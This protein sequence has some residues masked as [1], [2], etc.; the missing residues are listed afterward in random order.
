MYFHRPLRVFCGN[1]LSSS[2]FHL[3]LWKK[4]WY[5]KNRESEL[6][7]QAYIFFCFSLMGCKDPQHPLP[8]PPWLQNLWDSV[9]ISSVSLGKSFN[10]FGLSGLL[11]AK[12]VCVSRSILIESSVLEKK[13][14]VLNLNFIFTEN[15][16]WHFRVYRNVFSQNVS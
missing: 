14:K 7:G 11:S 9:L 8:P 13:N 5:L 12:W 1:T 3:L 15:R 4:V 16:Y 6:I 2:L 10:I